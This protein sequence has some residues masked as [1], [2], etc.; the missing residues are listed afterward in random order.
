MLA[1]LLATFK[2]PEGDIL[3]EGF[4]DAVA[5]LNT[6]EET[7]LALVPAM[8]ER[9]RHELALARSDCNDA[10]LNHQ[11]MLPSLNIRGLMSGVADGRIVNMIP[12]E[13]SASVDIRLVKGNTPA[14]MLDIV[15]RHI[16]RQ[17]F[18]IVREKPNRATRLGHPRIARIV[19][20]PGY[21]PVRT[22]MSLPVVQSVI[23]AVRRATDPDLILLPTLGGSL[24]LHHFEQHLGLPII[25]VP[26]ANHD[27]NQHGPDENLRVSNLWYGIDLFASLFTGSGNL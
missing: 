27:N 1:Q 22:D 21:P 5:P 9:L 14:A 15:E 26:I 19:H 16:E 6:V 8:D 3:V 24:P 13:A 10:P 11:L 25:G 2:S 18:H 23:E 7:A 17:G 20:D 4:Y 12:S